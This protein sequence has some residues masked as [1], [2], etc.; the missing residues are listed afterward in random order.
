MS[1]AVRSSNLKSKKVAK[2]PRDMGLAREL[3]ERKYNYSTLSVAIGTSLVATDQ[4][5]IAQGLDDGNRIGRTIF[6]EMVEFNYVYRRVVASTS[7]SDVIRLLVLIK[8]DGTTP[9]WTDIFA[10]SSVTS[11]YRA[12]VSS[13]GK[14]LKNSNIIVLYDQMVEVNGNDQY[15]QIVR[16]RVS[17]NW[18]SYYAG[19]TS[20]DCNSG[21]VYICTRSNNG[22]ANPPTLDGTGCLY[23]TDS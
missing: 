10:D 12:Q 14:K 22:G 3:V 9:V 8:D 6:S 2:R 18:P 17:I 19:T 13:P 23:Y 7:V 4:T 15:C 20:S 11:T 5:A 1:S 21:R 16:G